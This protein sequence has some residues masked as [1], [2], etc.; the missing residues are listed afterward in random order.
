VSGAI[1]IVYFLAA[2]LGL[3]L[4]TKPEGVAVFWPASGIAAGILIILGRR[5][6][7]ALV[8]GVVAATIAANLMGDRSLGTSVLK[9]LSNA[10]EAVLT[11]WLIERWFGRAFAFDDLRRVLGFVAAACLGAAASATPGAAT[12]T[13]F[14]TSAPYWDV[15]RAWFLSDGVGIVMVAPLVIELGRIR[16]KLPSRTQSIEGVGVLLL[17]ALIS[18]HAMTHPTGSWLSFDPD[19]VVLPLLLW[20]IARCQPIFGIAGAFVESLTVIYATTLGIGH[21]GDVGVPIVHRVSGAQVVIVMVT[22]YTLV[23]AALFTQRRES[24]AQLAKKSAALAHLHEISSRLWLKRDLGQALDEILAGAIELL[25]ADKGIIRTLDP[26][27]CMLKIEAHRGFKQDFIDSFREVSSVID[28]PCERTLQSGERIVIADVEEDKLFTH[29]RPRARSAGVRAVQSTPIMSRERVPLGTLTTHFHLVHNPAEHDL[30]LLDLYVRQAAD[31]IERHK[32]ED[33]LLESE[34]RLRLAQ[35]RTGIGIWDWNLRSGKVTW[36]PQLEALFGLEPGSVQSYA[37]FRNRVHPDDI[38][39]VEAERDAAVRRHETFKLEFRVL[40]R[41]GEVRWILAAGGAVYD[42]TTGEPI[43][44]LGNN[45]DITERKELEDHKNSLISELDHRV[46]N[47]LATVS[48]VVSR[49]QETSSSLAEFVV[50]LDGRIKSMANTHDLLSHRRWQGIPLAELVRHELAPYATASN[51]HIDG[52]DVALS[53]EASQTFAM[54][55]H[56]LAT[57]AAKYGAISVRSGRV[58]V[59]WR[60]RRNGHVESSL[61]IQWQESGGPHVVPPNRSGFGTSV[62]RELVPY[63][64]GGT[65]DLVYLPDGLRFRAEIPVHWL[66]SSKSTGEP[67]IHGPARAGAAPACTRF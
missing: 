39:A 62:V 42:E 18:L 23:L 33:A 63:E 58:S 24:E 2:R 26:T 13:L 41:D 49:T 7:V 14:H 25:G 43:R 57:N 21:F 45:I 61:L 15:W 37:D 38:E 67:S 3:A 44:I 53:A 35:L 54:V 11:A 66:N 40:C 52:P 48:A 32:A 17:L 22:L 56:E 46:K 19:A 10:S 29:F 20:L 1:A 59:S 5:V 9:G 47:V 16:R 50:A 36:T 34:E 6:R 4:L 27:R 51:S 31:I 12:M 28:S 30:R 8:I 64:L 60:Y 65:V 55:F